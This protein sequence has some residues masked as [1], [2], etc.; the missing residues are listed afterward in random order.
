M[1]LSGNFKVRPA[2]IVATAFLC[3]ILLFTIPVHSLL[4]QQATTGEL[5][6]YPGTSLGGLTS[7]ETLMSLDECRKVCTERKGCLGF[8]HQTSTNQ[9]R[10]FA[11]LGNARQDSASNAGSRNPIAGYRPPTPPPGQEKVQTG[12]LDVE[13]EPAREGA[14]ETATSP[15]EGPRRKPEVPIVIVANPDFDA[16]GANGVIEG[17]D[18]SGDGF[19]AVRS[20]PGAKYAELDRLYNGEQVYLCQTKG[21]WLGVVYSKQRQDCNVTTPWITT[22]P[23]T[24]PC[25]SGWVHRNWV[26]LYAG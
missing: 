14:V 13:R 7:A 16:C 4:A 19:L 20:G 9:C 11:A 26:R 10:L 8:D 5:L 6:N 21:K 3:C 23:Y 17:L 25:K 18:P 24:G 2:A 1:R 12:K 15:S 22:Q